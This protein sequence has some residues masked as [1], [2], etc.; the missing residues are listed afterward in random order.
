MT[1]GIVGPEASAWSASGEQAARNLI[2]S[3]LCSGRYDQVTSGA[4]HRGGVGIWAR[5]EA[6]RLDIPMVEFPPKA[7]GWYWYKQRNQRIAKLA[8]EVICIV[9]A[10]G[11]CK[12]CRDPHR[13]NGGC[14]TANYARNIGKKVNVLVI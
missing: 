4:C 1:L 2:R 5:E 11:Y 10:G 6:E 3:Y 13:S 14:W 8:H 12:H 9:P 7:H